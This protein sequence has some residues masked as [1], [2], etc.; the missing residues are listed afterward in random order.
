MRILFA[1]SFH[2]AELADGP[3]GC[4]RDYLREL[5][6]RADVRC[7]V[8]DW[9]AARRQKPDGDVERIVEPQLVLDVFSSESRLIEAA[10]SLRTALS[11]LLA[12]FRPEVIHCADAP[13]FLPFRFDKNVLYAAGL[14]ESV[15]AGGA[16]TQNRPA[17]RSLRAAL[18]RD[19]RIERCAV[20]G[21]AVLTVPSNF[22]A[23]NAERIAG[24]MCCPI[25]LPPGLSERRRAAA[26]SGGSANPDSARSEKA[27][28]PLTVAFFGRL[29][30]AR[31][32]VNDFIYAV[33]HL[34]G[35]FKQRNNVR[36]EVHGGG[37]LAFG[38]D[39]P[40][41][42]ANTA[43][44]GPEE[45]LRRAD[46]VVIPSRDAAFGIAALEAMASGAL[47]LLPPG[48]GMDGFAEP[49][50]N[51]IPISRNYFEIADAIQDAVERFGQY[52][53]MR[54]NARRTARGWSMGR[55]VRAYLAVY[56]EICRGRIPQ[57]CSAYRKES[58]IILERYRKT[59]DVEKA[60]CAEQERRAAF[61]A[62]RPL[63]PPEEWNGQSGLGRRR[64]LVLTGVYAP[65]ADALPE[66]IAV[67]P[68][69]DEQQDGIVV[70]PECLPFRDG[71]F[72][73]VVAVG[74]LESAADPCGALA[75]MQRVENTTVI[76]LL[77]VCLQG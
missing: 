73:N 77:L 58:R 38:L 66:H 33:N 7:V 47:A 53:F 57:L 54:D 21:S 41:L 22:A 2:P 35:Q 36:F 13:A 68:T 52:Q 65:D 50:A 18:F 30:D 69:L 28:A 51:C 11:P 37:R 75:E 74:A 70:R 63:A 32:G 67:V 25:V 19:A 8:F 71:E 64:T 10:A 43:G 49:E 12:E 23:E 40:L 16:C 27:G 29:E 55:C 31:S 48:F 6:K 34:G 42:D 3:G 60:Y 56:R 46:I 9:D 39:S 1:T 5:R 76:L 26:D 45:A 59:D 62:V 44:A 4:L 17:A 24:G 14:S 20:T 15:L 61:E 72:E